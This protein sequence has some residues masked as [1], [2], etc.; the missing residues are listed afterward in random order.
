MNIFLGRI[1]GLDPAKPF[2]D[3]ANSTGRLDSD[4]AVFVDVIHTHGGLVTME[5]PVRRAILSLHPQCLNFATWEFTMFSARNVCMG[6]TPFNF[7]VT[8]LTFRTR[9][10]NLLDRPFLLDWRRGFLP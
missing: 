7:S 4:D 8:Y 9:H 2:F 5:E 6:P 10:I 3:V 1:T